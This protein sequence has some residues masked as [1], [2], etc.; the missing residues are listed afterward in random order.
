MAD[1]PLSRQIAAV[2]HEITMRRRLYPRWVQNGRMTQLQ[3]DAGIEAM[4]AVQ[5]TLEALFVE[6]ETK[7]QP[8]LF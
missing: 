4:Q 2:R 6:Q 1:I 8:G 5:A 3:A 7:I